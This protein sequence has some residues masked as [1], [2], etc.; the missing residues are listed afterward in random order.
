MHRDVVFGEWDSRVEAHEGIPRRVW[1]K[2]EGV[3]APC[4]EMGAHLGP[5]IW[6][7]VTPVVRRGACHGRVRAE[8]DSMTGGL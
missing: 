4:V 7:V 3:V 1:E 6:D 5:D 2:V 8:E